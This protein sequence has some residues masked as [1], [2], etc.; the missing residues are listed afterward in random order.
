MVR[1]IPASAVVAMLCAFCGLLGYVAGE[2]RGRQSGPEVAAPV[3]LPSTGVPFA[4]SSAPKCPTEP[5]LECEA[6]REALTESVAE[7]TSARARLREDLEFYR[8]LV[9]NRQAD[10][11]VRLHDAEWVALSDDRV[12]LRLTLV[13]AGPGQNELEAHLKVVL[14]GTMDG[15]VREVL[16][17]R[18]AIGRAPDLTIS[19][20][21]FREWEAELRIPVSFVPDRLIVELRRSA[22]S[23][24][25]VK[26]WAWST[27]ES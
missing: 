20:K 26:S 2:W 23:K 14:R 11:S 3:A 8:G 13:R 9:D 24:P 19:L 6:A 7:L 16:V 12:L 1:S 18:L 27:L 21:N 15:E 5:L 25:V 10:N 22:R 4:P 17:D